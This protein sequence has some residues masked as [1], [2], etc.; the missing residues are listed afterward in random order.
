MTDDISPSGTALGLVHAALNPSGGC[1]L[2]DLLERIAHSV[3]AFGCVLWEEVPPLPGQAGR[4]HGETLFVLESWFADG[5]PPFARHDLSVAGSI[6][7]EVLTSGEPRVENHPPRG[8]LP[9]GTLATATC[10]FPIVHPEVNRGV[11]SVYRDDGRPFLDADV[12]R[13]VTASRLL[14]ILYQAMRDRVSYALLKD[15]EREL[16]R[17]DAETD[18]QIL[19]PGQKKELIQR[20]CVLVAG[21][22]PCLEVSVYLNDRLDDPRNF[23]RMGSTLKDA[24][25]GEA[26]HRSERDDGLT[27]WV[28]HHNKPIRIFDLKTFQR[29]REKIRES[30]PNIT[31]EDRGKIIEVAKREFKRGS[32][33]A[34]PPLSLMAVPIKAGIEAIGVI[35]LAVAQGPYYFAPRDERLID[36]VADQIAQCWSTW[37]SRREVQR[38]NDAWR[39]FIEGTK[40]LNDFVQVEVDKDVVDERRIFE[41]ALRLV[42][43]VVAGAEIVSIRVRND[44]K[45]RL[46]FAAILPRDPERFKVTFP[47][48]PPITSL[49]AQVMET[50]VMRNVPDVT[51]EALYDSDGFDDTRRM[52]VAPLTSDNTPSNRLGVIDLRGTGEREFP[53]YAEQ[54][55]EL[56]GRQLGMYHRLGT[57]IIELRDQQRV[58][59]QAWK[60]LSHQLKSP[61][62]QAKK[63]A[64]LIIN[65]LKDWR[66]DHPRAEAPDLDSQ[67]FAIR[68]LCRKSKRVTMSLALLE[69]LAARKPIEMKKKRLSYEGLKKLL[70]EASMD[71]QVL[72]ATHRN[73]KFGVDEA[74]FD[75]SQLARV[76]VDLNLL[77]QAISNLLDNAGKYSHSNSQVRIFGGLT[78]KRQFHISVTN[79]GVK[80]GPHEVAQCVKREWRGEEA[81]GVTQEGSGIGLW[82]V[83]KIMQEH[84]GSLIIVPTKPNFVTEVKLIFPIS[85]S[86]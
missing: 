4:A 11:L 53:R 23:R 54:V 69:S 25:G 85:E 39:R 49:G 52:I 29:D 83:D 75:V 16:Q 3:E 1:R 65:E 60:D 70:I 50:G 84:G 17:A 72:C 37:L 73:I 64:D 42:H 58:K 40:T 20:L 31:W 63:R 77:E 76:E 56:L 74:T 81:K 8:E 79:R 47:L 71:S 43:D 35:R 2:S 62:L 38:E 30:Y 28:I 22:L 14:P 21:S 19:T 7:G 55:A 36:V 32:E 27:G 12:D 51:R 57:T 44:E 82:I 33:E 86:I 18:G 78:N 67:L 48:G 6:P 10:A 24:L 66:A 15:V 68:G 5:H 45:N 61:I 26:Y 59:M 80:I 34:L 41:E 13:L 46:Q 9:T